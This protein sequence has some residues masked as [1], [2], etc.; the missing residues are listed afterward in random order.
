MFSRNALSPSKV[1]GGGDDVNHNNQ[2]V[3]QRKQSAAYTVENSYLATTVDNEDHT[4]NGIMFNICIDSAFPIR[5]IELHAFSARGRLGPITIWVTKENQDFRAVLEDKE[6]WERVYQHNHTPSTRKFV[7]FFLDSPIRLEPNE[8]RGV[9]IHSALPND[10]GIVYDNSRMW[11]GN[12]PRVKDDF[13]QVSS[14]YA[15]T[16][17]DPFSRTF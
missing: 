11:S 1:K 17:Y 6:S 13:I 12:N 3:L 7:E 16:S 2:L 4:F 5:Y 14:A 8:T 10:R 15:H 9:Y